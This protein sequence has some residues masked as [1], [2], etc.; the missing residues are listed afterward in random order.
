MGIAKVFDNDTH[1]ITVFRVDNI[2]V[3][4]THFRLS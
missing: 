4:T 3:C 1:K 2:G